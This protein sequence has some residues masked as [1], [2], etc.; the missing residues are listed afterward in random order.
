MQNYYR[1]RVSQ[2]AA[3]LFLEGRGKAIYILHS[4]D[5][6]LALLLVR[7]T[8]YDDDEVKQRFE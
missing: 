5:P 2:E 8:E 1:A 3:S 4:S 6:N 7:F